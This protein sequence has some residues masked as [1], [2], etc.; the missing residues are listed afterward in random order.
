MRVVVAHCDTPSLPCQHLSQLLRVPP[1]ERGVD[2]E[3]VRKVLCRYALSAH[4]WGEAGFLRLS[5]Y[6][7][8]NPF[9][10]ERGEA[11][12]CCL[13]DRDHC[14]LPVKARG[15]D[16]D[17]VVGTHRQPIAVVCEAALLL[18]DAS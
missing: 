18:V 15:V 10:V 16:F 2:V 7:I 1:D 11:K 3:E 9:W 14:Y 6:A 12:V 4:G 8:S 13:V 17:V 5:R